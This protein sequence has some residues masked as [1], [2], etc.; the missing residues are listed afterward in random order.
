MSSSLYHSLAW[1]R[2]RKRALK[3]DGN[4]CTIARLFGGECSPIL[5]IH[6]VVPVSDGGPEIPD[7]DGVLTTCAAHH[8]KLHQMRRNLHEKHEHPRRRCPHNHRYAWAKTE[9]ERK[10]NG[11]RKLTAA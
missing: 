3:R 11:E 5:N 4:A 1:R 9:C 8:P 2:L 6:H 10:L 7:L